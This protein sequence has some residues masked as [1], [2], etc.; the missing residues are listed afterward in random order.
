MSKV[1]RGTLPTKPPIVTS[2]LQFKPFSTAVLHAL[3]LLCRIS[4]SS[5][6]LKHS[7]PQHNHSAPT[8]ATKAHAITPTKP[9][10]SSPPPQQTP[11]D[12]PAIEAPR[13]L[14]KDFSKVFATHTPGAENPAR[15][16]PSPAQT[17]TSTPTTP[18]KAK[19]LGRSATLPDSEAFPSGSRAPSTPQSSINSSP[20]RSLS[21]TI[22]KTSSLPN[23]QPTPSKSADGETPTA[24][25]HLPP[26][27]TLRTYSSTRSFLAPLQ[28]SFTEGDE[29]PS[30]E[31]DNIESQ[32]EFHH[33]S[34]ADLRKKYRIDLSSDDD[35]DTGI[36]GPLDLKTVGELRDKGEN[37]RFMD[38]LGYL[39]E[40]LASNMTLA[41]K[42]LR[43]D[44]S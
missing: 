14:L 29:E 41:V 12:K 24:E 1:S 6:T 23:L 28:M 7:E 16:R 43:Y 36:S 10:D 3:P 22:Q 39:L 27:P 18:R 40:G 30:E 31:A 8:T 15:R 9:R 19:M 42:R 21:S 33:E 20:A 35:M 17:L 4:G 26:R 37:R 34:Y 44:I 38:D 5:S 25:S 32:E 11:T 13:K 2:K